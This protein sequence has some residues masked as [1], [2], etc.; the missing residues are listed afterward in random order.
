MK[1]NL[2]KL[3][4]EQEKTHE[5]YMQSLADNLNT[6]GKV[7]TIFRKEIIEDQQKIADILLQM[8]KTIEKMEEERKQMEELKKKFKSIKIWNI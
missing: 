1:E 2:T 8:H 7:N 5:D 6:T 3:F 4:S